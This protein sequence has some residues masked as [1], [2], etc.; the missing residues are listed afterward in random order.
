MTMKKAPAIA[1]G[2]LLVLTAA[3]LIVFFLRAP[4]QETP[5]PQ[6]KR[7][8][9][10]PAKPSA[11]VIE[12]ETPEAAKPAVA[13]PLKAAEP[14]PSKKAPAAA[15][16]R[17]AKVEEDLD[18]M[19]LA[20]REIQRRFGGPALEV[21][22]VPGTGVFGR[23]LDSD[24]SPVPGLSVSLVPRNKGGGL[25][26]LIGRRFS[27][28]SARKDSS[29]SESGGGRTDEAGRFEIKNLDPTKAYSIQV[30]G[31]EEFLDGDFEAP[32]LRS[33]Q[34]VDA[35]E[36]AINRPARISGI[37]RDPFGTPLAGAR[38]RL[39]EDGN[40]LALD[41]GGSVPDVVQDE[42]EDDDG[43]IRSTSFVMVARRGGD[44]KDKTSKGSGLN[45]RSGGIQIFGGAANGKRS[46]EDGSYAF[47]K[48]APGTYTVVA[49]FPKYR[50]A[51]I[52]G[53]TVKEGQR[54]D[55]THL[56]L[57][58]GGALLL[59]VKDP[60]GEGVAGA[61]V[62][63]EPAGTAVIVF[64]GQPKKPGVK[65]DNN[66]QVRLQDLTRERYRATVTAPGFGSHQEV[67]AL[68]DDGETEAEL[69]LK[70]G[71]RVVARVINAVTGA[72]IADATA[73]INNAQIGGELGIPGLFSNLRGDSQGRL[74]SELL[75]P[76]KYAISIRA[77]H[78]ESARRDLTLAAGQDSLD[79]GDIRLRPLGSVE[80]TVVDAEGKPVAGAEVRSADGLGGSSAS[81]I[82][83]DVDETADGKKVE[84]KVVM[85]TQ[86]GVA[87][88]D[89]RGVALLEDM[90]LGKVTLKA[91]KK[92][93]VTGFA[94]DVLVP[95]DGRPGRAT[96]TLPAGARIYGVARDKTDQ[97]PLANVKVLLL[98]KGNPLPDAIAQTD[99]EGRF[100][101][102]A[103]SPGSMKLAIGRDI[104]GGFGLT[105]G[106]G[107]LRE[108]RDGEVLS[109]D[110]TD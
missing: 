107:A 86:T 46:A 79:L 71:L 84:R 94:E 38:V 36:L 48:V 72:P 10:A 70:P 40:D 15:P 27:P 104:N 20:Q 103:V 53:L 3:L 44:S 34:L 110:V 69:S 66:G 50:R 13:T 12:G 55:D 11:Y 64:A 49:S 51:L 106:D 56:S 4:S 92:G 2:L 97:S 67:I 41:L 21:K 18:P 31:G 63:L 90:R 16:T 25:Q 19:E 83:V 85:G 23:V 108:V 87:T 47:D 8:A 52:T 1:G 95:E 24:R 82:D 29:A 62:R 57:R 26:A 75:E 54:R 88:T 33:G 32:T 60:A 5:A 43:R 99:A 37:I 89:A 28:R 6:G 42:E 76:G 22:P 9:L 58:N 81:S 73:F 91:T 109:W 93:R 65:T 102:T 59:T 61:E 45:A 78:F 98:R 101:F 7:A 74:R 77:P 39:V 100:E 96:I 14:A 105:T 17:V 80:V 68:D 35:G 30:S